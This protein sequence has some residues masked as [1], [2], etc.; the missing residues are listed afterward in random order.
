MKAKYIIAMLLPLALTTI[1]SCTR[2]EDDLFEKSAAERAREAITNANEALVAAENGWEFLY[3][4]NPDTRGYNLL[5]RLYADGHVTFTAKNALTTNNQMQTDGNSTWTLISDYGPLLSFDTYNEVFHAWS[6]PQNDGDG[7]L[8]DYEF[9]ILNTTAEQIR[10]KGKKHSAYSVLNRLPDD[11]S[12]EDYYAQVEAL[13]ANLFG[14]DNFLELHQGG[15]VKSLFEGSTGIFT[16][17]EQGQLPTEEVPPTFPLITTRTGIQLMQ[18][19]DGYE[20]HK[21]FELNAERDRLQY[22]ADE[23]ITPGDLSVYV[24]NYLTLMGNQ[25]NISTETTNPTSEAAV[26]A[27]LEQLRALSSNARRNASV[28][29]LTF[30]YDASTEGYIVEMRY[31]LESRTQERTPV[32]FNFNV[33]AEN[34]ALTLAYVGPADNNAQIMLGNA[35]AIEQLVQTLNGTYSLAATVIPLNPT[36]GTTL[37]STADANLWFTMTGTTS[38]TTGL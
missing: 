37:T 4:C 22:S 33:T 29:G 11:L 8:G 6:D 20:D 32:K 14:N 23:Y 5:V 3:F 27:V 13:E 19:F 10:L 9:L 2:D 35:P 16:M 21:T 12:W 38:S 7:Y 15:N 26:A 1:V 31:T 28:R 30:R 18:G 17:G 25:W 34:G 24:Q 36:Q